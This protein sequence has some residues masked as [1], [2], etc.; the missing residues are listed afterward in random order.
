MP[1]MYST[2]VASRP[3]G[4]CNQLATRNM[5]AAFAGELSC[6]DRLLWSTAEVRLDDGNGSICDSRGMPLTGQQPDI[7]DV[8]RTI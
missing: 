2:A 3:A 7:H 1:F 8:G 4:Y 5:A 6:R